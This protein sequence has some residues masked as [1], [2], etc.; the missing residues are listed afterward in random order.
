ML[1][2]KKIK[3]LEEWSEKQ[4][5][6][7]IYDS[8]R[9]SDD[10]TCFSSIV[11]HQRN[12]LFICIDQDDMIFGGYYEGEITQLDSPLR[13]EGKKDFVFTFNENGLVDSVKRYDLKG[14]YGIRVYSN[15]VRLFTFCNAFGIAK[16]ATDKSFCFNGI[17][18]YY[19][20]ATSISLNNKPDR[21]FHV[22]RVIVI[23]MK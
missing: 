10:N 15:S 5:D 6:E 14:D 23:K 17:G 4:I 2:E 7:I 22:N 16:A 9:N 18:D 11:L 1:T 19:E 8:D 21:K 13:E 12:L 20:G 3:L